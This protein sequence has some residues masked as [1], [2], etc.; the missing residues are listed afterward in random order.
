M[1]APVAI[2]CRACGKSDTVSYHQAC[3][4][5]SIRC[6]ACVSAYRKAQRQKR[7]AEGRPIPRSKE[8]AAQYEQER[9]A[10]P[11]VRAR[12][13]ADMARYAKDPALRVRHKAR[14][15]VRRAIASGKLVRQPCEVCGTQPAHGHHD[16]YS[17]PLDVR[18][19]CPVHHREHHARCQGGGK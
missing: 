16:D 1:N 18:W 10:D 17:K 15:Q 9:R 14:W 13:A 12:R 19:L 8:R 11:T 2:A 3:V 5:K 4:Q 6:N 7:N